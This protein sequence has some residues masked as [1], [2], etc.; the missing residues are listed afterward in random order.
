MLL[1]GILLASADEICSY[2]VRPGHFQA[3]ITLP[4]AWR[5]ALF[6]GDSLRIGSFIPLTQRITQTQLHSK[7]ISITAITTGTMPNSAASFLS[8]LWTGQIKQRIPKIGLDRTERNLVRIAL[9]IIQRKPPGINSP[10]QFTSHRIPI[11]LRILDR[12]HGQSRL[13]TRYRP[14]RLCYVHW[15][16]HGG[17]HRLVVRFE[18]EL[19]GI[20]D[21]VLVLFLVIGVA[22]HTQPIYGFGYLEV[23]R[24][25][26]CGPRIHMRDLCS[27]GWSPL[28][29][30]AGL[31]DVVDDGVWRGSDP[32]LVFNTGRSDA[33]QVLRA[34]GDCNDEGCELLAVL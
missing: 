22:V 14:P 19:P 13:R 17:L 25:H 2:T 18:E 27:S 15:L 32:S 31:L 16:A 8:L 26:P 30:I 21:V 6:K 4:L 7:S 1:F 23:A 3:S 29:G 11:L 20:L 34:A 24:V 10:K 9:S 5:R 12:R 33:V 28:D